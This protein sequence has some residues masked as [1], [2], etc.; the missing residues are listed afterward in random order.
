MM[1]NEVCLTIQIIT[2]TREIRVDTERDDEKMKRFSGVGTRGLG[3]YLFLNVAGR[4]NAMKQ[5]EKK[6][7]EAR[8]LEETKQTNN[9]MAYLNEY[10][11][12][13]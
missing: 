11:P 3:E 12:P 8:H 10:L 6:K 5:G 7:E 4:V 1:L 13:N 9:K 2:R